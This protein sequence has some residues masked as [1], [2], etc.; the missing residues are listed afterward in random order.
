MFSGVYPSSP[1]I[2]HYDTVQDIK[3]RQYRIK[4]NVNE[5]RK[6]GHLPAPHTPEPPK[7]KQKIS[8]HTNNHQPK[9]TTFQTP[10][11][12]KPRPSHIIFTDSDFPNSTHKTKSLTQQQPV[13]S[14]K[15][16]KPKRLVPTSRDPLPTKKRALDEDEDLPRGG[17]PQ[18]NKMQNKGRKKKKTGQV[19]LFQTE[20]HKGRK[21]DLF[22][23]TG[24][25]GMQKQTSKNQKRENWKKFNNKKSGAQHEEDNLFGIKQRKRKKKDQFV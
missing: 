3:R 5:M 16:W 1:F 15:P 14:V 20:M 12:H 24:G 7:K 22:C 23:G 2:G 11:M 25:G 18:P 17:G 21:S 13:G 9:K 19:F 10:N 8:H 4:M 6:R